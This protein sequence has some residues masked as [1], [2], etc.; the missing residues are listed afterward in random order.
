MAKKKLEVTEN[1]NTEATD[2]VVLQSSLD[3]KMIFK[4]FDRAEDGQVE[5]EFEVGLGAKSDAAD[6]ERHVYIDHDLIGNI[7]ILSQYLF[8]KLSEDKIF[9]QCLAAGKVKVLESLPESYANTNKG[10]HEARAK[11][12]AE[13]ARADAAEAANAEKDAELAELRA[14]LQA[15]GG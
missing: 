6:Y 2:K 1:E 11:A 7:T 5:R 15:F 14:K 8:D 3:H 10:V 4:L 9:K 12:E 13:K